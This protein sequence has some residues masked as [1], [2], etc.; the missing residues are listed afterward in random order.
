MKKTISE[1]I[2]RTEKTADNLKKLDVSL[3]SLVIVNDG[4]TDNTSSVIGKLKKKFIRL[5]NKPKNEGPVKALFD[6]MKESLLL[7]KEKKYTPDRTIMIRMDSDLE[8]QPEDI[9]KLIKPIIS[10][11]TR[12]SAGY[13]PFDDRSGVFAKPFN[14]YVGLK[15]SRKFLNKNIPQFCPGFIAMRAD[16]SERIYPTLEV[17]SKKFEKETGKELLTLDFVALVIAKSFGEQISVV[18]LSP[19]ESERIKKPPLEKIL[20]Y[21]DHHNKNMKFLKNEFLQG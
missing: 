14:E 15:E 18:R 12:I 17:K 19:I 16:L 20:Y 8:H 10:G 9:E 3:K 2:L 5:I 4:S 1:M 11:E 21:L 13:I 6:G 7:M